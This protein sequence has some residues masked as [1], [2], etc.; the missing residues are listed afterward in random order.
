LNTAPAAIPPILIAELLLWIFST[1]TA[2]FMECS[3]QMELKKFR[4]ELRIKVSW[5][6]SVLCRNCQAIFE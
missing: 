1:T 2:S 6:A 4:I 3:L 5:T